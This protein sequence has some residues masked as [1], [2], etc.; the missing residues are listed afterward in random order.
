MVEVIDPRLGESVL[1]PA[2][3]TGGFLVEA[4]NHLSD[5]VKTVA[6]RRLLQEE[7][8]YGCEPKPLPYF[9]VR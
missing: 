8:I 9:S 7:A 1:D 5:Q 4:F 2:A 6:H 3:G